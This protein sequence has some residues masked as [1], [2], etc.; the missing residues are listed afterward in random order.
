MLKEIDPQEFS[1]LKRS[2]PKTHVFASGLCLRSKTW[3]SKAS[4]LERRVQR[5]GCDLG[6]YVVKRKRSNNALRFV[7]DLEASLQARACVQ[8][9]CIKNQ[10]CNL[11]AV[12]P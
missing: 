12:K 7:S 9:R 3:L 2:V 10:G 1:V 6:A 11:L 8:V 4:V 5:R